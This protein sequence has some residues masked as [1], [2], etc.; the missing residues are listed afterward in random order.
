LSYCVFINSTEPAGYGV[1]FDFV[2][3]YGTVT[4]SIFAGNKAIGGGDPPLPHPC[5][6]F[7]LTSPWLLIA[8]HVPIPESGVL[9]LPSMILEQPAVLYDIPMQALIGWELSNLFVLEV[10]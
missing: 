8:I 9:V 4:N 7:F 6:G 3:G 2:G 1:R 5:G 10:R